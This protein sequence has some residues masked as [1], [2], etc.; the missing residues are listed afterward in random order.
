M[1]FKI[2][3]PSQKE[4][5]LR[6]I[7]TPIYLGPNAPLTATWIEVPRVGSNKYHNTAHYSAECE[8]RRHAA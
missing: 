2:D 1:R 3:S 6:C 8:V 7:W 5:T 4:T